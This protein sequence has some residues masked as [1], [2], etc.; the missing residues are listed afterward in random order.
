[1][2]I[3]AM[4]YVHFKLNGEISRN[5]RLWEYNFYLLSPPDDNIVLGML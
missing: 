3:L 5:Q 1:M 4:Y 2:V